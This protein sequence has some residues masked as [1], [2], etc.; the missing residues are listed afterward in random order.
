[1]LIAELSQPSQLHKLGISHP[2]N[3]HLR[4]LHRTNLSR[5]G[6]KTVD[7]VSRSQDDIVILILKRRDPT[8]ED[9]NL[10]TQPAP[11][12]PNLVHLRLRTPSA[13]Q[14]DEAV[15]NFCMLTLK[16]GKIGL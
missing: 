6:H 16:I 2:R 10:S 4:L 9:R 1:M 7:I 8:L 3:L 15:L 12:V 5:R 13:L 11:P 14:L